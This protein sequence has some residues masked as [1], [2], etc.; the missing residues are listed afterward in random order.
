M[1]VDRLSSQEAKSSSSLSFG[2]C[3]G[4]AQSR[5]SNLA[6]VLAHSLDPAA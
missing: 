5:L 2:T 6:T 4:S 3:S 1:S